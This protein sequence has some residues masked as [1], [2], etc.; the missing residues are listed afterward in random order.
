MSIFICSKSSEQRLLFYTNSLL[1]VQGNIS[2]LTINLQL[3]SPF[4]K[5]YSSCKNGHVKKLKSFLKKSKYIKALN[6][7]SNEDDVNILLFFGN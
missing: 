6:Y 2:I 7:Y 3:S 1:L 4:E 5:L